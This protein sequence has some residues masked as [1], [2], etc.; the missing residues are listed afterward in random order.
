MK[1]GD[2]L[3]A[4]VLIAVIAGF[5]IPRFFDH[6]QT[7][8]AAF[9]EISVNGEHYRTVS[10]SEANQDIEIRTKRGYN[11]LRLSDHGIEMIEADCPDKL[12][13]GFGHTHDQGD[14]IICL[15]NRILVEIT[16]DTGRGGG[17]LDAVVS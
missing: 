10:L 12:C 1:K 13:L 17:G 7:G 11:L 2:M 5:S 6:S 9:A 15:P 3:I 8:S 16:G 4:G 14:T